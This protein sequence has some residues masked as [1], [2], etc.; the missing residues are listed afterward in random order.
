MTVFDLIAAALIGISALIGFSRGA[1]RELVGLFAFV[2]SAGAALFLLPWTGALARH[3]VSGSLFAVALA[4]IGGFAVV[5]LAFKMLGHL[6][7]S[8]IHQQ[9]LLGGADRSLGFGMGAA[10]ALILLG[11]FALVFEHATPEDMKP[12]WITGGFLY[13]LASASGRLLGHFAPSGLQ[14]AGQFGPLLKNVV[15]ENGEDISPNENETAPTP[16][17]PT[18]HLAISGRAVQKD[19]A[20]GRTLPKSRSAGRGYTKQTRDS[21]DAIVEKTR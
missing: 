1:V 6:L 17:P 7:A 9:T 20:T 5:Y 4:V 15:G 10:R 8:Q 14:A 3:L 2:V 16:V 19:A 12:R 21:L 18:N 11:L 13:P